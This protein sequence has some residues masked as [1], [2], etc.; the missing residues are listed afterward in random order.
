MHFAFSCLLLV[1]VFQQGFGAETLLC[2]PRVFPGHETSKSTLRKHVGCWTCQ[3]C[4]VYND[5]SLLSFEAWCG[6]WEYTPWKRTI[7]FQT[8][9]F[10]LFEGVANKDKVFT[11]AIW[12]TWR[13]IHHGDKMAIATWYSLNF[14]DHGHQI[15]SPFKFCFTFCLESSLIPH[16]SMAPRPFFF[17]EIYDEETLYPPEI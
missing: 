9:I 14:V 7:I 5:S 16:L 12:M 4:H 6:T 2:S 3:S 13:K 8:I 11:L 1:I 15:H 17:S 10:R